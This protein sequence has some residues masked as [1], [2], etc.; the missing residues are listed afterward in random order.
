MGKPGT[1]YTVPA[2]VIAIGTAAFDSCKA[3]TM[4]NLPVTITSIGDGAFAWCGSL[5]A[6]DVDDDNQHY[7]D[8]DGVLFTRDGTGLLVYP[9]GKS[10]TDYTV[11]AGVTAI[12]VYAFAGYGKLE[13]IILPNGF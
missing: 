10:E 9:M 1:D 7:K 13:R 8:Q 11:P 4:I 6:I 2:G 12:G 3:L 5:T